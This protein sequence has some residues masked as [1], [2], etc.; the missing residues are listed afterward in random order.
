MLSPNI[1]TINDAMTRLNLV[2]A[3]TK[4]EWNDQKAAEFEEAVMAPLPGAVR[5]AVAAMR[6]VGELAARARQECA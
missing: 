6:R 1:S 5:T 2:W 4:P 3:E